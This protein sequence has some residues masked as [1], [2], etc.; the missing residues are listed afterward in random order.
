[1]SIVDRELISETGWGSQEWMDFIGNQIGKR[2]KPIRGSKGL[3]TTDA[4]LWV[5]DLADELWKRISERDDWSARD[6]N[7]VCAKLLSL[8]FSLWACRIIR[9]KAYDPRR[10]VKQRRRALRKLVQYHHALLECMVDESKDSEF[11]PAQEWDS[12]FS[13][14]ARYEPDSMEQLRQAY[15]NK[16]ERERKGE[17]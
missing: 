8:I 1:M 17:E 15:A 6:E 13:S 3:Q 4:S 16:K 9:A 14:K 10:P 12:P 5:G 2:S 7:I 11:F